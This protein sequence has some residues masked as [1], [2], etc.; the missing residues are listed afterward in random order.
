M[1]VIIRWCRISF[2]SENQK[3]DPQLNS[4]KV[5][6]FLCFLAETLFLFEWLMVER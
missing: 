5:F 3:N 4:N 6:A 2:S 1:V